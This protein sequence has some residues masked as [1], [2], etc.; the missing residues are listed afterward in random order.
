MK[1]KYE[2]DIWTYLIEKKVLYS[3]E[4]M[5]IKRYIDDAPFTPSFSK[6]SPGRIGIWV[7][8]QIVRSYMKNRTDVD[9][10]KLMNNNNYQK[11]L[12]RSKYKP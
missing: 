3:T 12:N 11:I 9:L 4:Y 5:Q 8:W 6:K 7:G 1:K 2:E 10:I